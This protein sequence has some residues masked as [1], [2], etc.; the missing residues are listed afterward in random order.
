MGRVETAQIIVNRPLHGPERVFTYAVPENL[1][2]NI[3][4]GVRVTVPF[5][6]RTATGFVISVDKPQEADFTLKEI[7]SVVDERPLLTPVLLRL[8]H[9]LASRYLCTVRE[10]L[11]AICG[12][13]GRTQK[14]T[15]CICFWPRGNAGEILKQIEDLRAPA[16][17]RALSVVAAKPGITRQ[18][19]LREAGVS[20]KSIN[21]LVKKGLV[22][23][24]EVPA[25][26]ELHQAACVVDG[27]PWELNAEQSA[28]LHVI[29]EAIRNRQQRVYLLHGVTASGKTEVY[30][31]AAAAVIGLGRQAIILVPEIALAHQMVLRF[32]SWFGNQV[33]VTHSALSQGARYDEW[34]R[35]CTG[36]AKVVLGARSAVFAPTEKLGLIVVDEEHEPAYKQEQ[37]PRYHAREVALARAAQEG[38]VVILGSATPALESWARQMAGRYHYLELSERVDG[39]GLPTVHV[40]D[41][42]EEFRSGMVNVFSRLLSKQIEERLKRKEQVLLFLNR[43]GFAFFALCRACGNV[44]RCP[45]CDI[46]LTYH[47]PETLLCHY[48]HYRMRYQARCP[49]CGNPLQVHGAGTQRVEEEAR[50]LFPE[51]RIMRMDAETTARRG[52]LARIMDAF[53]SGEIDVLIGTQMVAKGLDIPGV[54]LVGVINADTTLLLPDFRAAERTFQ[55]LYQ[56]AGRAGRGSRPGEVVIQTHCPE[57]YAV[58]LSAQQNFSFFARKELAFR[59]RFGYPPYASLVRVVCYGENE[60]GVLSWAKQLAAA[61]KAAAGSAAAVLGPAPCPLVKLKGVYRWHIILKGKHGETVRSICREV[62]Q[63]FKSRPSGVRIAVDVDPQSLL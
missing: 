2:E 40:V 16:Q 57:H 31:R 30:L 18:A 19:L 36:E 49:K 22:T 58:R 32:R 38:S 48:C 28:A 43:R 50:A 14:K 41:L 3:V 52:S 29:S 27:Q 21:A 8:G 54:T 17:V 4:P 25:R 45:N 39:R 1:R 5:G 42:R 11:A 56:V 59:K 51:A 62:M 44:I 33:A 60:E 15:Q 35:V 24:E 34:E 12:P 23:T 9:W 61:F 7:I 20:P 13:A 37:A 6:Q 53:R 47:Q 10:A 55:L 26:G 63:H 46:A